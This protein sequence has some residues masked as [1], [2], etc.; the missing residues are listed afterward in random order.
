MMPTKL[1]ATPDAFLKVTGSLRKMAANIIVKMGAR[2]PSMAESMEVVIVMAPRKVSCGM[3]RPTIEASRM[4]RRSLG[5]TFSLGRKSEQAQNRALAPMALRVKS[6]MGLTVW[7]EAMSLQKMILKPKIMYAPAA[8]RCPANLFLSIFL[9]YFN[10]SSS[11]AAD[12]S[13]RFAQS[14]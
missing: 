2:V 13:I 7:V 5:G 4:R 10:S 14:R 12:L 6:T 9:H 1:I 3:K 11:L 8:A